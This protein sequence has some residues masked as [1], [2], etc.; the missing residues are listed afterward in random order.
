MPDTAPQQRSTLNRPWVLKM[1]IFILVLVAFGSWG[2]YDAAVKYPASGGRFAEWAE[3]QY[4]QKA[5]EADAEEFGY[6]LNYAS[7]PDPKQELA[8]L[9]DPETV[10]KNQEAAENP[11]STRRLRAIAEI[12]RR[13][14]LD[15]LRLVGQMTPERTTIENPR[16]R[17]DE[18]STAWGTRQQPTAL[19]GYD[20]PMQWGI[21]VGCYAL[22]LYLLYLFVRVASKSYRWDPEQQ[23][24]AFP[25]G[26]SIVPSD[27]A[28]ID[29][30]KWD[31]FIVFLKIND[32]HE[33]LG[34]KEVRVDTY[35][36]ARVEGW[37]L[38]MEKT[39]FPPEEE[40]DDNAPSE[41][42]SGN[43]ADA[44]DAVAG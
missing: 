7:V 38:E 33:K 37:I 20:I 23:R 5:R 42:G 44:S 15:G 11:D 21:M 17:L 31:K 25:G 2:L 16:A 10:R 39:R 28:E 14:W 41:P 9:S 6:F 1:L 27:L 36:H 18:L 22:A 29:K 19:H 40:G 26:A 43:N 13:Q 3:W 4:L 30:R 35:R 8:H 12:T 32:G 24:L 34:G